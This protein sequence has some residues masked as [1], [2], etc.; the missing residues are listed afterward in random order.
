MR[1]HDGKPNRREYFGANPGGHPLRGALDNSH[2]DRA[3]VET[4]G[5]GSGRGSS[6]TTPAAAAAT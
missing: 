5:G 3:R 6:V 2:A 4:L 1:R